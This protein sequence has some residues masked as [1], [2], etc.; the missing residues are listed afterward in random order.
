M[1][2]RSSVALQDERY[3]PLETLGRG[4][5]ASVL[6]AFD[7]VEQRDVALKVLS[8]SSGAG[9]ANPLSAEFDVWSRLL[10]PNVVRAY[11]LET[12]RTGPIRAGTPYLVLE[13]VDG[14]PVHLILRAGHVTPEE[15]EGVAVQVLHG[16]A[17]VHDAGLVHRDL[18]PGNVLVHPCGDGDSSVKLTDFGLAARRGLREPPGTIN[19]SIPYIAPESLLGRPLDGRADLYGLG[20]L[21]YHLATG[22]MP[23]RTSNIDDLI[24]WHLAGPAADPRRVRPRFPGRLGRFIARLTARSPE[25]RPA[26]C[27]EALMLLGARRTSGSEPRGAVIRRGLR[28]RLRLALDAARLGAFRIFPMPRSP[29]QSREVRRQVVVWSQVHGLTFHHLESPRRGGPSTLTGL[30]LGLLLRSGP[31]AGSLA[32]RY[33]LE[34]WLPL[35]MFGGVPVRDGTRRPLS[36]NADGA[37]LAQA[38]RVIR[39]FLVDCSS[40]RSL[41]IHAGRSAASDPLTR[42]VV[43]ELARVCQRPAPDPGRGGLLLLVDEE[44]NLAIRRGSRGRG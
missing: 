43:A 34:R 8:N 35:K 38:A 20:I 31:D 13:H 14:G 9:P 33:A 30:A 26:D 3:L 18:K 40:R 23:A 28:A 4:G 37:A 39:R 16:L 2:I 29:S 15:I 19:G 5:M 42:S 32:G 22:E 21:L 17:H 24:R 7:R 25:Q 41:V 36:S 10:H 44:L 27:A 6:R 1:T 11:G 12:A